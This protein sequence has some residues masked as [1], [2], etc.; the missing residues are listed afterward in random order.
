MARMTDQAHQFERLFTERGSRLH[1]RAGDV[2]RNLARDWQI[3]ISSDLFGWCCVQWSW[4]R[5]GRM[6]QSRTASFAGEHEA[7]R[8]VRRLLQRRA[9]APGRIGTTYNPVG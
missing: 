6:G 7:R 9:R 1:L 4:G 5:T 8:L 2:D 3:E